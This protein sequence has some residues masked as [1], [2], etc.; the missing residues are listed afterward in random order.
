MPLTEEEK[1]HFLLKHSRD[2]IWWADLVTHQYE[3]MSPAAKIVFGYTPDEL[4][5]IGGFGSFRLIHPDDQEEVGNKLFS[6]SPIEQGGIDAIYYEHRSKHPE[7]GYRWISTSCAV[8]FN[9]NNEPVALV[10]NTRDIHR[11]KLT[12]L[13]LKKL[14]DE[15]E[16]KVSE[17]TSELEQANTA[18]TLMLKKEQELKTDFED[19]ILSNLKELVLP[20]MEKLKRSRLDSRERK[21]LDMM[22]L[23][24]GK[25]VSPF[26]RKLSSRFLSL[27]PSEIQVADLIR[28]GKTTKE[29]AELLNLSARTIE[30]HR[31]NI[32]K[33]IGIKNKKVSLR[34]HLM[35]FE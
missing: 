33:K 22:E 1:F 17:R 3:Y 20:Y 16:K 18:L 2:A 32:R 30:G 34:S 4:K 8:V 24:L 10:G 21:Y 27:T 9:K 29:I 35:S 5:K 6:L 14:R 26:L 13:A 31:A 15:L 28:H 19:K 12:E 7:L 25:I 23:N 11:R